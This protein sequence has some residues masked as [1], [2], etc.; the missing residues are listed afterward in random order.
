MRS[1][2]EYYNIIREADRILDEVYTE[3]RAIGLENLAQAAFDALI[4]VR[5]LV[6]K[7]ATEDSKGRL[8]SQEDIM[9]LRNIENKS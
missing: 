1:A 2:E 5:L 7:L 3:T 9:F 6:A 8:L 4:K